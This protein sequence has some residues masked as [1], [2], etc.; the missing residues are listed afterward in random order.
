M[1]IG[2]LGGGAWG[3]VLASLAEARGHEVALWEFDAGEAARLGRERRSAR[4]VPG[5]ELPAGVAV[6]NEIAGAVAGSEL[7]VVVVPS[8]T[9]RATMTAAAPSLRPGTVAVCAS[10]GLEPETHLTMAA[11]IG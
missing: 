1:K 2:V 5:F 3:T 9:V 7:V 4:T 10:K 8:D 11:V 6:T